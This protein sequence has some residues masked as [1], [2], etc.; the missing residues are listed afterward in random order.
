MSRSRS[1]RA[2][3]VKAPSL[4][5][6]FAAV[7]MALLLMVQGYGVQTH[8]HQQAAG[9]AKIALGGSQG[10]DKYP[11]GDDLNCPL[12][13]QLSHA[14]Q[15]IAP[16]WALSFLR[17]LSVSTADMASAVLPHYDAVSHSW[18]GRGPPR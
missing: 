10:H 6:L 12:C 3:A 1:I 8:I 15:F 11:A 18:R 4:G 14:G 17:V 7:L 13:Q 2:Q 9:Q 5:G 16:N